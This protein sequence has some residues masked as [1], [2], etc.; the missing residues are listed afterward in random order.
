MMYG[1]HGTA[2]VVS[3]VQRRASA[4]LAC[5]RRRVAEI[6]TRLRN[7]NRRRG[8]GGGG[9]RMCRTVL[10]HTYMSSNIIAGAHKP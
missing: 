2:G 7:G 6:P 9:R 4:I 3:A 5:V 10:V 1:V 8:G